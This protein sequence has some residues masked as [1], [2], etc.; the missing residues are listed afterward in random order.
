MTQV[1]NES[2]ERLIE[3]CELNGLKITNEFSRHKD[4]HRDSWIQGT[5][6]LCSIIDFIII[7]KNSA[8]KIKYVRVWIGS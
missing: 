4:I 2:G 7:R 6:D 1:A 5:R 3:L 8:M